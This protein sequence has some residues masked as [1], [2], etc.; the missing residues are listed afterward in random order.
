MQASIA[1]C[2]SDYA[3]GARVWLAYSGGVDSTLMLVLSSQVCAK[4]SL[5]LSAIHVHH[6]VAKQA[7]SWVAHCQQ[8]CQL[9]NVPLCVK[10][11]AV[12]DTTPE[13]PSLSNQASD[14]HAAK[15][16]LS[17]DDLRRGRYRI[18]LQVMATNEPL[19]MAHH[20]QDQAETVLLRLCRG[21]SLY[22][23]QAMQAKRLQTQDDQHEVIVL[24]PWLC[25]SR[26]QIV[27]VA[28]QLK[29]SWIE[30]PSNQQV[31]WRRNFMRHQV[32]PLLE[33]QWPAAVQ[34]IAQ[35]AELAQ[36]Q[37]CALDWL[38]KPYLQAILLT[39]TIVSLTQLTLLPLDV[40]RLIL[41]NWLRGLMGELVSQQWL[42]TLLR[43]QSGQYGDAQLYCFQRC[44][45]FV[46]VRQLAV[47]HTEPWLQGDLTGLVVRARQGGER[48]FR[49]ANRPQQTLKNL[50]QAQQVPPWLR[51]I[52]PLVYKGDQLVAIPHVWVHADFMDKK[53]SAIV[54]SHPC[55]NQWLEWRNVIQA[56]VG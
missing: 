56:D 51:Q 49:A 19:L 6:G 13:I 5:N 20:Q 32:L 50:F 54:W 42:N 24:R 1:A 16:K 53:E 48:I 26:A 22:G 46:D 7:D 10:Y 52:W 31:S 15:K 45:W 41:A 9:L 14:I 23:L 34:Q 37:H 39:P 28:Q 40:Q 3:P 8:Q 2:L 33:Q 47:S 12:A 4:L 11:L 29:I 36:Q 25:F 55:V 38:L 17:E 43:Q 18:F 21:T 27:A 30:D 44:I 35:L